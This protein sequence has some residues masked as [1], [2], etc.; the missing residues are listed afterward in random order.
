MSYDYYSSNDSYRGR[1]RR[2]E[3][4][5]GYS[6]LTMTALSPARAGRA[7]PHRR[8]KREYA[9]KPPPA[10]PRRRCRRGAAAHHCVQ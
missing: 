6:S 9:D 7:D 5:D 2:R 3:S 1:H 4:P 10:L 8:E